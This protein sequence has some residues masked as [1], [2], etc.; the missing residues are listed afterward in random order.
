MNGMEREKKGEDDRVCPLK[1][2]LRATRHT[3]FVRA[4]FFSFFLKRRFA[5]EN[6]CFL[7]KLMKHNKQWSL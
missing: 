4:A 6:S 2:I 5:R 1:T 3:P 7:V